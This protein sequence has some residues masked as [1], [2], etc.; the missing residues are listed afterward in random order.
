MTSPTPP[1]AGPLT[2]TPLVFA[3]RG[4]SAILPEH[5]LEAY[6]AALAQGADGV[7][8]DVR[9]TRDEHLVCVHDRRLERT[10]DGRGPVSAYTLAELQR[11][12]V[13]SWHN[14]RPA[15][16]LTLEDL[17]D[18]L[19]HAGRPVRLLIETK[20][21]ARNG[22]RLER[23][24]VELLARHGLL[25]PSESAPVSVGVLSFSTLAL[26]RIRQLAPELPV[27]QL[28]PALPPGL[29]PTR[30]PAGVR[31]AGLGIPLVRARPGVVPTLRAAGNEVYVWTVNEL[32]D[33]NL[34][35]QLGVDGIITDRPRFVLDQLGR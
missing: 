5:T 14:G 26:R 23:R 11:L 24:L 34:A 8:C 32:A 3:H 27:C 31:T 25:Q 33:L 1:G 18:L 28:L 16:I 10:S 29:R 20:H 17:L 6:S 35:R 30:L 4:A 9:L 15:R 21:P 13:G 2:P 22:H 19:R 7:E 12:D